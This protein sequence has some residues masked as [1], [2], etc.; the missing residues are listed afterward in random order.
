[1]ATSDP[2]ARASVAKADMDF[3]EDVEAS[4]TSSKH[5]DNAHIQH[6]ELTEEDVRP[7]YSPPPVTSRTKAND[8]R[9]NVEQEDPPQD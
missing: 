6:V 8:S 1:M 7:H 5:D 2:A 9:G 4:R 3:S